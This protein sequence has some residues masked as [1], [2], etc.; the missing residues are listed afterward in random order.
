[1]TCLLQLG[2]VT[3]AVCSENPLGDMQEVGPARRAGCSWCPARLKLELA[4]SGMPCPLH[5]QLRKPR[6]GGRAPQSAGLHS[7]VSVQC[8]AVAGGPLG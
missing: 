5:L 7:L 2:A 4:G 1:M 6:P 8:S 3:R